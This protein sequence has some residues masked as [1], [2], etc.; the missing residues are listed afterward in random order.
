M[1][2]AGAEEGK[3]C[4]YF[5]AADNYPRHYRDPTY[6]E[7]VAQTY[8]TVAAGCTGLSY[9][10]GWPRTMGNWKAYLQL[11]RELLSLSD[12]ITS[13]EECSEGAASGNP[14]LMRV[15]A[16]KHDGHVYLIGCNIDSEPAGKVAFML[17]VQFKYDGDAEVMFEDRRIPV[18]D[19]AFSD[20]FGGHT[21]HVYKIKI[22]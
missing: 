1:W 21:R 19:G 12:V 6:A 22:R 5:L 9:F 17:P 8:G 10:Y 2:K 4:F 3:P 18:R 14:K 7:Q 13:E 11:N 20:G 15:R 16:K